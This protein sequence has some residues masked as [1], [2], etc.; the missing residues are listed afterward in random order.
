[1]TEG[2]APSGIPRRAAAEPPHRNQIGRCGPPKARACGGGPGAPGAGPSPLQARSSLPA[3]PGSSR[4]AAV[5]QPPAS[6]G[7][8]LLGRPCRA[9]AAARGSCSSAWPAARRGTG[10]DA[11]SGDAAEAAKWVARASRPPSPGRR[12]E[13]GT[14]S[15][16]GR[17]HHRGDL[18]PPGTARSRAARAAPGTSRRSSATP[19]AGCRRPR[20][21]RFD[22]YLGRAGLST[23]AAGGA[24]RRGG[25]ASW[26]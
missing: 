21:D 4:T 9:W 2:P 13:R 12:R 14:A 17:V 26:G 7:G 20:S 22:A 3:L 11:C 10:P 8:A 1:M 18:R 6:S 23:S 15:A 24:A 16:C 19:R 5:A 25:R